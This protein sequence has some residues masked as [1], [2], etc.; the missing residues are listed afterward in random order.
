M[1][2]I[3]TRRK[4]ICTQGKRMDEWMKIWVPS[5]S[6]I[7][8]F[9]HTKHVTVI[10]TRLRLGFRAENNTNSNF[11]KQ[12]EF[13]WKEKYFSIQCNTLAFRE[14]WLNTRK[15]SDHNLW[16]KFHDKKKKSK[17]EKQNR[18]VITDYQVFHHDQNWVWLYKLWRSMSMA[19]FII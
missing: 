8:S 17:T 16:L 15:I 1:K 9:I 19:L 2:S 18:N 4:I 13:F 12:I 11:P 14:K 6:P 3:E 5:T 10:N 7:A